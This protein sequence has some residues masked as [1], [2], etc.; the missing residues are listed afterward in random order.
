MDFLRAIPLALNANVR[1][2]I[3]IDGLEAWKHHIREVHGIDASHGLS[4][5]QDKLKK[6][7]IRRARQKAL[8]ASEGVASMDDIIYAPRAEEVES[9]QKLNVLIRS[10]DK[11]ISNSLNFG[12][13]YGAPCS[14]HILRS[15]RTLESGILGCN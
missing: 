4:V 10:R 14:L 5:S 12:I 15:Q 8:G 11:F 2:D 1:L 13:R 7:A 6:V 9:R 3:L